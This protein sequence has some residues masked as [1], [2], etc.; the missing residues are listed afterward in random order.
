MNSEQISTIATQP[1]IREF[2]FAIIQNIRAKNFIYEEKHVIHADLVPKVSVRVMQ[3]SLGEKKTLINNKQLKPKVKIPVAKPKMAP[4][5][6]PPIARPQILPPARAPPIQQMVPPVIPQGM[7]SGLSQ[8]YG[9]ITPLLND[10][11]VSMIECQGAEKPVMVTRAGQKQI[12]KIIL[13][14]D[15]IKEILDKISEAVHIP[16]LEGMF[17]AA[18]DNFSINAIISEIVGSKFIIK[19]QSTYTGF[20]TG[21]NN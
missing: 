14:A 11:S 15:D 13:S 12:T 19:K 2:V 18:V 5:P 7:Q 6:K 3:A 4:V 17:R 8:T 9:K 16:L 1:F 20:R 10:P 21:N